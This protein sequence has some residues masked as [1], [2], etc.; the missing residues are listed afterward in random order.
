MEQEAAAKELEASKQQV[1]KVKDI[2]KLENQKNEIKL[3]PS[4][5]C[6]ALQNKEPNKDDIKN[7]QEKGGQPTVASSSV[8]RT[9]LCFLSLPSLLFPSPWSFSSL[10]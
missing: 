9:T 5:I 2:N 7:N 3:Y 4:A 8:G 1:K 10:C 6:P